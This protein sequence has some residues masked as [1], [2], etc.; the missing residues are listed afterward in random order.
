M[1]LSSFC[2][3]LFLLATLTLSASLTIKL[4]TKQTSNQSLESMLKP[5]IFLPNFSQWPE[6]AFDTYQ[7]NTARLQ[8]LAEDLGKSSDYYAERL[9]ILRKIGYSGNLQQLEQ[10]IRNSTDVLAVCDLL[11]TDTQFFKQ[12]GLNPN[13]LRALSLQRKTIP[14]Q[15][16]INLLRLYF[17]KYMELN[18]DPQFGNFC[19]I[20]RQQLNFYLQ[21]HQRDAFTTNFLNLCQDAHLF[22]EHDPFENIINL[23]HD[24]F[25]SFEVFLSHYSLDIYQDGDFVRHCLTLYY[26]RALKNLPLDTYSPVLKQVVSNKH[27]RIT[28]Q[29]LGPTLGHAALRILI[30]RCRGQAISQHWLDTIL[31]IAEDPRLPSSSP[32][33]LT[34]WSELDEKDVQQVIAWLSRS[35]LQF[36]LDLLET[37]SSYNFDMLRMFPDRKQFIESLLQKNLVTQTRLILSSSAVNFIKRH[38]HNQHHKLL[39]FATV[40]GNSSNQAS[41]ICINL[42]NKVYMM[43]GTHNC[44]LRLIPSLSPNATYFNYTENSFTDWRCRGGFLYYND[45]P[46]NDCQELVHY[47]NGS[48][49]SDAKRYLSQ[50]GLPVY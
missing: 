50:H 12:V 41:F 40:E 42:S 2:D 27:S 22:F 8:N 13:V 26:I 24:K 36:F 21:K 7:E 14:M 23:A 45:G 10:E 1:C 44:S 32:S 47:T 4:L 31:Q 39:Q 46:K 5:Q 6:H 49:I 28:S 35:D 30:D 29:A 33:Y 11:N 16:V 15:G 43:E 3:S 9:E 38:Y 48:W 18:K 25:S 37:A 19:Q 20:L 34:W 17:D